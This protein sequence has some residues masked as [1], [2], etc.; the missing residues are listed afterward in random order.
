MVIRSKTRA[1]GEFLSPPTS[2][3]AL[4]IFAP[5]VYTS[6]NRNVAQRSRA[7]NS[8]EMRFSAICRTPRC[9]LEKC[10][11]FASAG[12]RE[13]GGFLTHFY[14]E[15]ITDVCLKLSIRRSFQSLSKYE[16][17]SRFAKKLLCLTTSWQLAIFFAKF[18]SA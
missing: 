15:G 11:G 10:V 14:C 16:R 3:L 17:K 13:S 8:A 6:E 2:R 18:V 7:R 1:N 5:Q 12:E 9:A 4:C